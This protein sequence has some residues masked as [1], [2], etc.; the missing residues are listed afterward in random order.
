MKALGSAD[1]KIADARMSGDIR[2][3]SLSNLDQTGCTS[4]GNTRY[5]RAIPDHD[6][7]TAGS[8]TSPLG[9]GRRFNGGAESE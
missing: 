1:S 3:N 4:L 2:R 7:F 6:N 8:A 5:T 9:G